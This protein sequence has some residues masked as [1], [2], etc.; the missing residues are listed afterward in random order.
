M[1]PL[2]YERMFHEASAR[3]E[4]ERVDE[5]LT[6]LS[7]VDPEMAER[8]YDSMDLSLAFSIEALPLRK[9]LS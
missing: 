8:L 9:G 2:E 5:I 7:K 3:G 4:V 1:T 6:A